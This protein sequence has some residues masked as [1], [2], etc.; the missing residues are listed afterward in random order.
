MERGREVGVLAKLEWLWSFDSDWS[1]L[2]AMAMVC[3][4]V[5][6]VACVK[7]IAS[8]WLENRRDKR[9]Y[10][11][12]ELRLLQKVRAEAERRQ[13]ERLDLDR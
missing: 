7:P 8:V 6:V 13:A 4:T 12:E 10:A 11:I 5:I 3:V 1:R 2:A 9:K